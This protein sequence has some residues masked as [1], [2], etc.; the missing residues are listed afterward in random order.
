VLAAVVLERVVVVVAAVEA[1]GC[2]QYHYGFVP[3]VVI[4][5]LAVVVVAVVVVAVVAVVPF[6]AVEGY[7]LVAA[8]PV[9][10]VH[11]FVAESLRIAAVRSSPLVLVVRVDRAAVGIVET[12]QKKLGRNAALYEDCY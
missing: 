12:E 7:N 8:V 4:A 3:A 6:V 5:A 10:P 9:E 11:T 2:F 1:I